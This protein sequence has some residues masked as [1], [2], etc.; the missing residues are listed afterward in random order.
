MAV[1]PARRSPERPRPFRHVGSR[2]RGGSPAP[3][4]AGRGRRE[5]APRTSTEIETSAAAALGRR[6]S[7]AAVTTSSSD[8]SSRWIGRRPSSARARTSRSSASRASRSASS[9]ARRIV[10]SISAEVRGRR[11]RARARPSG[12][13]ASAE[14]VGCVVD[15]P[16]FAGDGLLQ[17]RKHVVQRRREPAEL[18]VGGR[19]R[20]APVG[21]RCRDRG[22]L[23]AHTLD[24]PERR[25]GQHPAGQRGQTSATGPPIAKSTS[26]RS[27]ASWRS[28]NVR[29]ITMNGRSPRREPRGGGRNLQARHMP[30]EEHRP[31]LGQRRR[32]DQR[33]ARHLGRG[34]EDRAR[35][36]QHLG[37]GLV[38]VDRP[39]DW[40]SNVPLR[41][42]ASTTC[43]RDPARRR[44][45]P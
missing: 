38:G 3:A 30:L 9:E 26:S 35:R 32:G 45:A 6:P 10:A 29:P 33:A 19:D 22:G 4:G 13:R 27:R 23:D 2:C 15:E 5:L 42:P 37:E 28:D 16:A 43:A 31:R 14:L 21:L 8:T 40:A 1:V 36:V 18:V 20:Q 44:S 7:H 11:G 25:A 34:F 39:P 24:R 12:S 41:T 17:P